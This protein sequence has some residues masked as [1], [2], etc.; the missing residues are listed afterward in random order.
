MDKYQA[1]V[2]HIIHACNKH[3][4]LLGATKL[5]KVLW[6]SDVIAYQTA[7]TSITGETYVKRQFGPVPRRIQYVLRQLAAGEH[8]TIKEP[9]ERYEPREFRAVKIPMTNLLSENE[10]RIADVVLNALLGLAANEVS[11]MSHDSVWAAAKE[12]VKIPLE[13]TLVSLPREI[14]ADMV[15]WAKAAL[16]TQEAA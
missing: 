5:N 16:P 12:G 10:K 3:P 13:A 9:E 11:E 14:T 4:H 7:G 6:F 2:H 1:L 8:I 15:E